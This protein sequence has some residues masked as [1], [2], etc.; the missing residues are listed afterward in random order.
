M[1]RTLLIIIAFLIALTYVKANDG[2]FRINGNELIP[3][4]NTN[5]KVSKEIL[6]IKKISEKQVAVSVYY[7]FDNP[8]EEQIVNVGFEASPPQEDVEFIDNDTIKK[9]PANA[10]HRFMHNFT[11]SMNGKILPYTNKVE[12]DQ[13][14]SYVVN[15][16][17]Y[18]FNADFVTGKNIIRHSYVC[19]FSESVSSF[20]EFSY[21]LNAAKRWAGGKIGDFTLIIDMGSSASFAI[22]ETFFDSISDWT[23]VG[24]G[25]II[26]FKKSLK[27]KEDY[28]PDSLMK[29]YIRQGMVV[30]HKTEFIPENNLNIFCLDGLTAITTESLGNDLFDARKYKNEFYYHIPF[31]DVKPK[32]KATDEYSAKV[33]RNIPFARKGY[34]FKDQ[35][36]QKF[37][38]SME[39]YMPDPNYRP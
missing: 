38:E 33:L 21:V 15:M 14:Y 34:I 25:K 36:L 35:N 22:P 10:P 23:M 31:T 16:Y 26:D 4:H 28:S 6:S 29:C 1:K 9:I 8:S 37:F 17:V 24:N 13:K 27:D 30:F 20:Y 3:I 5:I 19:D 12:Y 18:L 7:E 32:M 39:W 2:V 11:V